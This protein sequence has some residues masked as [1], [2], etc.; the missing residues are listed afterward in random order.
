MELQHWVPHFDCLAL[1]PN[2]HLQ[3][4]KC[5]KILEQPFFAFFAFEKLCCFLNSTRGLETQEFDFWF[6]QRSKWQSPNWGFLLLLFRRYIKKSC[7]SPLSSLF[8]IWTQGIEVITAYQSAI[9]SWKL[10][11][12][13][14]FKV[15]S[16]LESSIYI[17]NDG[18]RNRHSSL[19]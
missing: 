4:R 3:T 10:F 19:P 8:E 12:D 15:R 2:S 6:S 18:L 11:E 13:Q 5:P 7:T 9:R 1:S 16:L 14:Y 17:E